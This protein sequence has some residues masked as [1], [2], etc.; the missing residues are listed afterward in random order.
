MNLNLRA[1][2]HEAEAST[3][4]KFLR[5][6]KVCACFRIRVSPIVFRAW[7][8]RGIRRSAA[9]R[10][11]PGPLVVALTIGAVAYLGS[12]TM[13]VEGQGGAPEAPAG[14]DNLTNGFVPQADFDATMEAF[15]ER[16]VIADGLGPVYNAQSCAECH[17]NPVTGAIS[18][19]S[20]MRSGHFNGRDFIEHP[21]G[22]LIHSRAIDAA[23]QETVLEGN[24]VRTFRT[25]LN[26]LGDGFIEAISDETLTE[27]AERQ[28]GE[29]RGR[30]RGE[31]I[32]VPVLEAGG[33]LRVGRFG[34][35]NQ[36]ASLVSFAADAYLNEMG[37][38]SPLKPF[39]NTSIGNAVNNYDSVADPE[40]DGADVRAFARF[41]RATKVPPRDENLAN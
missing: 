11:C 14:F 31:V 22:S 41:I 28:P 3:D 2:P 27:I 29:S 23:L 37:I 6:K 9:M 35:K 12:F 7:T 19:V 20:E 32:R 18:Q 34:W 21:G 33:A 39:E 36:H 4:V 30:I 16:D 40:D 1:A 8:G 5:Q 10:H 13:V 15:E 17:Q 24:E 26:T 25:S 38:T